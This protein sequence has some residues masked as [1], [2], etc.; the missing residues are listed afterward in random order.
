MVCAGV[1]FVLAVNNSYA[2]PLGV[3]CAI[4]SLY[5]MGKLLFVCSAQFEGIFK[6]QKCFLAIQHDVAY[7]SCYHTSRLFS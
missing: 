5:Q 2:P 6:L 3:F 7:R 4:L 1:S